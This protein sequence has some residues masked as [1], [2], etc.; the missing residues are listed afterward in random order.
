M[1]AREGA[2]WCLR[3]VG[4]GER[5]RRWR[6]CRSV[7]LGHCWPTTSICHPIPQPP[8]RPRAH[9]PPS[10]STRWTSST[11]AGK[12]CVLPVNATDAS[13]DPPNCRR[14]ERRLALSLVVGADGTP[15]ALQ[16]QLYPD[17]SVAHYAFTVTVRVPV[18][19][20]APAAPMLPCSCVFSA[21]ASCSL[22]DSVRMWMLCHC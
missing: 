2:C 18:S 12:P 8:H 6:N 21:S 19:T 7:V 4:A 11:E 22:F 13:P 9:A 10:S 15:V 14:L 3:A 17:P 5:L 1:L 16:A 20:L